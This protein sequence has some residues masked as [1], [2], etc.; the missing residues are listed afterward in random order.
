MSYIKNQMDAYDNAASNIRERFM[1]L[2]KEPNINEILYE[3]RY[4]TGK[5]TIIQYNHVVLK[6]VITYYHDN[7]IVF[8]EIHSNWEQSWS[9]EEV[10]QIVQQVKT[11]MNQE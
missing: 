8:P 2:L 11:I 6:L 3:L 4:K 7:L 5:L 9:K 1:V 10:D